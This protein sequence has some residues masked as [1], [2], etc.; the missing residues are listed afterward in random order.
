MCLGIVYG[1]RTKRSCGSK[2]IGGCYLPNVDTR[3]QTH[4]ENRKFSTLIHLS[5]QLET[6]VFWGEWDRRMK[7]LLLCWDSFPNCPF[8]SW[9][10][11][12][13]MPWL[14]YLVQTETHFPLLFGFYCRFEKISVLISR[15]K[16]FLPLLALTRLS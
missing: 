1:I 5:S 11:V 3:S 16:L 10:L 7:F 13:D 2:V 15:N 12:Y 8:K 4:R 14:T 9:D 6:V